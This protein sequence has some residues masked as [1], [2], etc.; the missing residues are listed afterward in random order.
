M[1]RHP[2][3]LLHKW[4]DPDS[5]RAP[6]P[7]TPTTQSGNIND[8]QGSFTIDVSALCSGVTQGMSHSQTLSLHFAVT[9]V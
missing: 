2:S 7:L 9:F 1:L 3:V 5:K 8:E 4:R 6:M